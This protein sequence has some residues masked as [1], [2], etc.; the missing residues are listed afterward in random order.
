M[1]WA[2]TSAASSGSAVLEVVVAR[3]IT[4]SAAGLAEQRDLLGRRLA[5]GEDQRGDGVVVGELFE[6]VGGCHG[7]KYTPCCAKVQKFPG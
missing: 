2:A 6:G 7:G 4:T 3:L 1:P 5:G